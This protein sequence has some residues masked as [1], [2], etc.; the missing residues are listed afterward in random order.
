[1]QFKF[2]AI[3]VSRTRIVRDRTCGSGRDRREFDP[4][5]IAVSIFCKELPWLPAGRCGEGIFFT[6]LDGRWLRY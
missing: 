2:V 1:M 5:L 4:Q 6:R 3:V